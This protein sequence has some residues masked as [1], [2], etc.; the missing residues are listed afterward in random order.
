MTAFIPKTNEPLVRETMQA[1]ADDLEAWNQLLY[2]HDNEDGKRQFCF[3]GRALTIQGYTVGGH[4]VFKGSL[5]FFDSFGKMIDN[6][7][8]EAAA[9]LGFTE[10]QA[11][12]IFG[13]APRPLSAVGRADITPEEQFAEFAEFVLAQTGID[14]R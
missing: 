3:A 12:D 10:S 7:M 5:R 14:C 2:V 13:W 8:E 6:T 4:P 11:A 1:I 9:E